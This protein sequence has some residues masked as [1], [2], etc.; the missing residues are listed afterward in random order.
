MAGTPD[1]AVEGLRERRRRRTARQLEDAALRLFTERGFDAVTVDD[2]A[3]EA[4]V[5]RR[6]FFRYYAAKEDV[7]LSDHPRHLDKLQAALDGRPADEPALTALRHA[8]LSLAG[9]YVDEEP[10][11]LARHRIMATAPSLQAR[12]LGLQRAWE[13]AVS[14]MVANRL[15][16]DEGTD[17]RPALVAAATLAALRT[18]LN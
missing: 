11:L 12:S 7:V 2:I 16:V 3:G 14:E 5:C 18:A 15:G 6:T 8:L 9:L 4:D 10:R 13:E 1:R 17:V